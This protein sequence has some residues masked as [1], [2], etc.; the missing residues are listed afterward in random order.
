V[1]TDERFFQGSLEHLAGIR[2]TVP[3]L[4]L[5]RKDF[6]IVPYQVWE[7]RCHGAD[8]VLLIVR[9]L[10]DPLLRR[11]L[12]ATGEAGMEALVEVYLEQ[13]LDR[14]LEAGARIVGI[15]NRDLSRFTVDTAV[16]ERLV[17]RVPGHVIAVSAS[18]IDR[19]EQIVRLEALGVRAFL[20]G[21][22]LV[23]A[24]DPEARLRELVS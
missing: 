4:P 10:T 8:A 13:D 6:L 7:A 14:A 9:A 5:L 24:A 15:N 11:L 3:D 21:E 23:T 18:G 20:I 1:L 12:D 16:T 22:A 19:R 2:A 17:P